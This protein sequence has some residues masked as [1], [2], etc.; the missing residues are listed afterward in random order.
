MSVGEI[1]D[2]YPTLVKKRYRVHCVSWH[3]KRKRRWRGSPRKYASSCW[4][5]VAEGHEVDLVKSLQLQELITEPL[6]TSGD[7]L[8]F[9]LR[10]RT[11]RVFSQKSAPKTCSRYDPTT[12]QDLN[13]SAIYGVSA[14]WSNHDSGDDCP[15]KLAATVSQLLTS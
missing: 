6:R 14:D 12:C 2:A 3:M 15:V 11:L 10:D 1:V 7:Q 5:L 8:R 13:C 9:A 4:L